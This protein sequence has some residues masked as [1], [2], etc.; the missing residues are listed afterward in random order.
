ML[1]I[2]YPCTA[3]GLNHTEEH[4]YLRWLVEQDGQQVE[5]AEGPLVGPVEEEIGRQVINRADD[6]V[7]AYV[8]KVDEGLPVRLGEGGDVGGGEDRPEPVQGQLV[9]V[10]KL[11]VGLHIGQQD[12]GSYQEEF[13]QQPV[14]E[15]SGDL[16]GQQ[17]DHSKSDKQLKYHYELAC[18]LQAFTPLHRLTKHPL[19]LRL[20]LREHV[21]RE[22]G[23]PQHLCPPVYVGKE[24]ESLHALTDHG[25]P[26]SKRHDNHLVCE[27]P[28]SEPLN[29]RVL[30]IVED[31]EVRQYAENLQQLL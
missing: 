28:L 22:A 2:C 9:S 27:V 30:L 19:H 1:S 26:T 20:L 7:L 16:E 8:G 21:V 6:D 10:F 23:E 5:G 13:I 17:E 29:R 14:C 18:A 11:P 24:C 31:C 3:E 12:E 25:H 15:G 4:E